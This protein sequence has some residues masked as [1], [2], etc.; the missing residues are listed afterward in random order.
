MVV[1]IET[2]ATFDGRQEGDQKNSITSSEERMKKEKG[3]KAGE[4]KD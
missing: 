3:G 1:N 2:M 4:Q